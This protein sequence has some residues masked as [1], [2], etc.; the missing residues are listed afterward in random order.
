MRQTQG[1]RKVSV[2]SKNDSSDI[3]PTNFG[4]HIEFMLTISQKFDYH[5][6]QIVH[7]YNHIY[8]FIYILHEVRP[9]EIYSHDTLDING[10]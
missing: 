7:I 2:G 10:H 3:F 4:D 8:I 6:S 5:L 9:T 1:L